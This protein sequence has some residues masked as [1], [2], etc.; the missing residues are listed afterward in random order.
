MR[1]A[2]LASVLVACYQPPDLAAFEQV[3]IVAQSQCDQPRAGRVACVHDGDTFDI[4]VCG[5]ENGERIRMLGIDTPE[6]AHGGEP[7]EC[8]GNE[9]RDE[10]TRLLR[11]KSVNLTFDSECKGVYGR[12]LAYVWNSSGEEGEE[13]IQSV[14]EALLAD[15]FARRYDEEWTADLRLDGRLRDAEALAKSRGL[16]LWGACEEIEG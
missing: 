4:G 3:P 14:N 11:S 9:A 13:G 10:L 16:G 12:T 6:V 8:Y 5:E 7:A 15:G 1:F 2:L